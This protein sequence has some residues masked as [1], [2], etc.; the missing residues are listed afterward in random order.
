MLAD[1]DLSANDNLIFYS[2][3][4]RKPCLRRDNHVL[5]KLAVVPDVHQIIDLGAAANSRG[6]QRSAIYGRVRPDF[7]VVADFKVADLR[8]FFVPPAFG[9]AYI[10]EAIAA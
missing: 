8:E 7:Y 9:I 6:F 1:A 10:S 2:D 4:P 5:A 3:A